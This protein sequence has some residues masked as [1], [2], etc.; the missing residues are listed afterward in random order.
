MLT[1]EEL[2]YIAVCALYQMNDAPGTHT[3][4]IPEDKNGKWEYEWQEKVNDEAH[5]I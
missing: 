2:I 1:D 5:R 3:V 4:K